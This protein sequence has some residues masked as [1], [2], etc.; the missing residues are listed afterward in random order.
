M[1]DI[2]KNTIDN[3]GKFRN[4]SKR[5][6]D[7][8]NHNHNHL[9]HSFTGIFRVTAMTDELQSRHNDYNDYNYLNEPA[10]KT[11]LEKI[12]IKTNNIQLEFT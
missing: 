6:Y 3:L 1:Q 4:Y 7:P 8:D 12:S 9:F 2:I 11:C 10:V 5:V